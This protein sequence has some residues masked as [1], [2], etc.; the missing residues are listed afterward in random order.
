MSER[1]AKT[2]IHTRP[3][4]VNAKIFLHTY[5]AYLVRKGV[6]LS[7]FD[8]VVRKLSP[9]ILVACGVFSPPGAALP[10]ESVYPALH[11]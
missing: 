4:E 1:H 9:T 10:L 6:E 3:S 7:E 11:T 5:I 8:R 2:D